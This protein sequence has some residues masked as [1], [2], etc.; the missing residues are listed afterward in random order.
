M[1]AMR[2]G[3]PDLAARAPRTTS[4]QRRDLAPRRPVRRVRTRPTTKLGAPGAE[5]A[6]VSAP[7]PSPSPGG[8]GITQGRGRSR[9][10]DLASRISC[11]R[12]CACRASADPKHEGA[13][14]GEFRTA[15]FECGRPPPP[16]ALLLAPRSTLRRGRSGRPEM[17]TAAAGARSHIGDASER[18][19]Q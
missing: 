7:R 14:D 16:A 8:R 5:G 12:A 9:I 2:L 4:F 6:R 11:P 1:E 3:A 13:R 18:D 19:A 10:L 15:S 17:S